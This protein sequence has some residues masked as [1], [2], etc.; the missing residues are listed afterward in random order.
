MNKKLTL[1]E[2]QDKP[3]KIKLI[4]E[5]VWWVLTDICKVLELTNPRKV[6]S[7]L[8]P[9]DVTSSYGVDSLGRKNKMNF[10]NESGLY[11]V[12]FQSRKPE[13]KAFKR[14]VTKEVLPS[15]RKTG[16][17]EVKHLEPSYQ[18]YPL[19]LIDCEEEHK[20]VQSSK[21]TNFFKK[22]LLK[23]AKQFNIIKSDK[24][25][26]WFMA[27][28]NNILYT[29][30]FNDVKKKILNYLKVY[31]KYAIL[32]DYINGVGL[33][34]LRDKQSIFLLLFTL[35]EGNLDKVIETLIL[36]IEEER[37]SYIDM[38]EKKYWEIIPEGDT[39]IIRELLRKY[40]LTLKGARK[41]V[42]SQKN[43]QLSLIEN[44]PLRITSNQRSIIK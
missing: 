10:V 27:K 43:G 7:T 15:I 22:R 14:W 26:G 41:E 3:V 42:N 34:M 40:P 29:I 2:Y 17:Y 18:H 9:D 30:C 31:N 8:D 38:I 20:R 19:S 4:N 25:I 28:V 13:A 32:I 1:F 6:A 37:Q 36:N 23:V 39:H 24:D 21:Y 35:Y 44:N 12:I 11:Q 33:D 16:K 5:E